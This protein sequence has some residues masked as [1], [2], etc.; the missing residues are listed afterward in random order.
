[1]HL[2]G[3][4]QGSGF[5]ARQYS[6]GAENLRRWTSGNNNSQKP[7][8]Q[9][10]QN[11]ADPNKKSKSKARRKRRKEAKKKQRE[12]EAKEQSNAEEKKEDT[13]MPDEEESAHPE[14]ETAK[15]ES[16]PAAAKTSDDSSSKNNVDPSSSNNSSSQ[17]KE[18][19]PSP[20]AEEETKKPAPNDGA[21]RADKSMD[22]W[23]KIAKELEEKGVDLGPELGLNGLQNAAGAA[24]SLNTSAAAT[25]PQYIQHKVKC[26]KNKKPGDLIEFSN[27]HIPGQ[28][29]SV[30]IPKD[31]K[32]GNFFKVMVPLPTKAA[33]VVINLCACCSLA[34]KEEKDRDESSTEKVGSPLRSCVHWCCAECRPTV[35]G[36]KCP[37]CASP[38]PTIASLDPLPYIKDFDSPSDAV[39]EALLEEFF[40]KK[41]ADRAD[42][43]EKHQALEAAAEAATKAV[44]KHFRRASLKVH[45]DRHGDT[46]EKEFI[47]LTKAKDL[48]INETLRQKYLSEM[49]DIICRV[50]VGYVPQSHEIWVQKNNPDSE[51]T[52]KTKKQEAGKGAEEPLQLDGGLAFGKPK[53]PI[54]SVVNGR[55][56]RVALPLKDEHQF[57]NYCDKVIIHGSCGESK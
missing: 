27:P 2:E 32:P 57:L 49:L 5:K 22:Q 35:D 17:P 38:L 25:T 10:N 3:H 44:N 45:P 52:P 34:V 24:A 47:A 12:Q 33:P 42:T 39:K 16:K 50:D 46:Y 54:L 41:E 28:K 29:R 9:E 18:E 21:S 56:I 20:K 19:P 1:M 48:L 23:E 51:D 7:A 11:T 43:K 53:R 40:A 31:A 13:S 37:T 6:L 30:R 4:V 36:K 55:K 14:P 8:A 15:P 26:P